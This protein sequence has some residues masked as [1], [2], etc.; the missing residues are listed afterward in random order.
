MTRY[1]IIRFSSIGDIILTT[2]VPRCL[3]KQHPQ[4]EIHFL[5]KPQFAGLLNNNPYID[6]VLTLKPKLSDTIKEIRQGGYSCIID[7]H[8]NIRTTNIKL[9]AGIKTYSF[10]KLNF[11]KW[12]L[13]TFKKDIMPN[14]HIVDRY[15]DTVAHLNVKNDNQGLDF[16]IPDNLNNFANNTLPSEFTKG[17]VCAVIGATHPTKQI[18]P[19]KLIAILNTAQKPVCLIGG[20]DVLESAT[21]IASQ[22]TVPYYNGVGKFSINQSAAIIKAAE[23]VITPD[24]GMMH[25]AAALHKKIISLW[26]NTVPELG[27]YPYKADPNSK[28]FETKGLSCRPCSKIGYKKCPKKHFHCMNMLD[29]EAI[30]NEL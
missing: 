11:R 22:L 23:S 12:I 24:T 14:V 15:M 9:R 18:P 26:G 20:N 3:K 16:F 10:N 25:I 5:T 19:S 4:A 29:I 27:M 13:T 8:H 7:L 17:F 28:I 6:K 2:P 1:L 21:Q 30:A